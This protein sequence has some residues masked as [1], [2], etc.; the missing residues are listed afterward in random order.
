MYISQVTE[1]QKQVESHS[2]SIRLS[3]S[4]SHKTP[5]LAESKQKTVV[6][7]METENKQKV[8]V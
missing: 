2:K 8:Q 6:Q 7:K 1:L 3:S 4:S 5:S